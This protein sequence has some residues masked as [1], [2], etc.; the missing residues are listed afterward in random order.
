MSYPLINTRLG[1]PFGSFRMTSESLSLL[2]QRYTSNYKS[3]CYRVSYPSDKT[4]PIIIHYFI[5]WLTSIS[6]T[7][8]I[9]F[10]EDT[11]TTYETFHLIN[12]YWHYHHHPI[13]FFQKRIYT[14]T[15]TV[16]AKWNSIKWING[17]RLNNQSNKNN[18]HSFLYWMHLNVYYYCIVLENLC[19]L[20]LI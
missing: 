3:S 10:S 8:Y 12:L 5:D 16:Y 14:I 4:Y 9:N 2:S 17:K 20:I 15:T 18:I 1:L 13:L 7:K 19:R 11:T 6:I